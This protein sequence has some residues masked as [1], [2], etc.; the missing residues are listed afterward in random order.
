M[1]ARFCVEISPC[2]QV[3]E[4]G[5]GDCIGETALCAD[6]A[7]HNASFV[8]VRDTELVKLSTTAFRFLVQEH[9]QALMKLSGVM[10]RRLSQ[11][12]GRTDKSVAS[13]SH[14]LPLL[15]GLR[16]VAGGGGSGRF[17]NIATIAIVPTSSAVDALAFART[18]AAS[19]AAH[20][21]VRFIDR[22]AILEHLELEEDP[23]PLSS[24]H[25][26]PAGSG[27]SQSTRL[28]S[29][30]APGSSSPTISEGTDS[31]HAQFHT[32]TNHLE[33]FY[34]RK[35]I[36]AFLTEQEAEYRYLLLIASADEHTGWSK[37]AVRQA[38]VVLLVAD[39]K[40][41]PIPSAS[42]HD[43]IW[44]QAAS[45]SSFDSSKATR[46]SSY[47]RNGTPASL[48]LIELVILH[49]DSC[50]LPN[51]TRAF[52]EARPAHLNLHH[53]LRSTTR[54]DFDR[55]ARYLGG[56][57]VGL[58]L[59]GGG[60][61]GLAHLG[62]IR[63]MEEQGVPI[64]FVGGTS[65]GAFMAALF[66]SNPSAAAMDKP[67]RLLAARMGDMRTL[68]RDFTLPYMSW[69]SGAALSDTL[70]L[71]FGDAQIEDLWVH[72]FAMT[73][74]I[75]RAN[76]CAH[77]TGDIWRVVRA[78]MSLLQFL[79]PMRQAN[80]DILIDGGYVSNLPVD[81]MRDLF[82]PAMM[83]AVDIESKDGDSFQ[84]VVNY[85]DDLS[86]FWIFQQ[87]LWRW[88]NPFA[89]S[90]RLPPFSDIVSS[91]NYIN[92]NRDSQ[93]VL[94]NGSIDVYIR[95]PS[96]NAIALLDYGR[97]DEIVGLGY[98]EASAQLMGWRAAL[99]AEA[100]GGHGHG[101]ALGL[102]SSAAG[103]SGSGGG[104]RRVRSLQDISPAASS[105][106][107]GSVAGTARTL[108]PT[109][110]AFGSSSLTAA[111]FRRARAE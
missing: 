1:L 61:R 40:Q 82:A 108:T 26:W 79:P 100:A 35:K 44:P 2:Q 69:F 86:G 38:D 49:P 96:M 110:H 50:A 43:L 5:R 84:N 22:T 27:A 103:S 85:G 23:N 48:Q 95:P 94:E 19:L 12:S 101:A 31:P 93:R 74:N 51:G 6:L 63:A 67:T 71:F 42:E 32:N 10:A 55:L 111:T 65:Q 46:T 11:M 70:K 9:P 53:H 80:G 64:D 47:A 105:A 109:G 73:T 14:S 56:R 52:L 21:R 41:D 37:C 15:G 36:S 98:R 7:H 99:N 97:V 90:L 72:C 106:A 92:H 88:V 68:I 30:L 75:S 107:H 78:S 76:A 104:I 29:H 24:G 102:S 33:Q 60:A 45:T 58:V 4:A 34:Y 18:L 89:D 81:A 25:T 17:A 59:S 83:V 54:A 39:E 28:R 77:R 3:I 66:A 13:V 57:S 87:R 62:A 91:L 8:C 16:Q 20:G